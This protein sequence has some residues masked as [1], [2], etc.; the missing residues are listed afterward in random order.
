MLAGVM[1][2]ERRW[3]LGENARNAR[4]PPP[5]PT[6]STSTKLSEARMIQ[7]GRGAARSSAVAVASPT[8]HIAKPDQAAPIGC[9]SALRRDPVVLGV[10]IRAPTPPP[11]P[12]HRVSAAE[13]KLA[14]HVFL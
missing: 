3:R 13:G 7:P 2:T 11:A 6:N 14:L 10:H 9:S 1:V 4:T 5:A 12:S 8:R